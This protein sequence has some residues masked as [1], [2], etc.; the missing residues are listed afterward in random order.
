MS[1]EPDAGNLLRSGEQP[2]SGDPAPLGTAGDSAGGKPM[3]MMWSA[4]GLGYS[5]TGLVPGCARDF[6]KATNCFRAR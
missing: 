1:I 3:N 5:V 2:G 6:C 4:V